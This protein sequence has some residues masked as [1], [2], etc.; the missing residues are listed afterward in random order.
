MPLRPVLGLQQS[1]SLVMT[2]QLLQSIKLLQFSNV[3]LD[4]YISS[5][6]ERNPLLKRDESYS[7]DENPPDI[8][9]HND[10]EAISERLDTSLENLFPDDPGS[11]DT[12]SPSL[13]AQWRSASGK[14]PSAPSEGAW[15]A[16]SFLTAPQTL[17]DQLQEQIPL[18]FKHPAERFLASQLAE[19][20]EDSGYLSDFDDIPARTGAS[21]AELEQVLLTLQQNIDPPGLFARNLAECLALQLQSK[22]RLDPAMRALLQNLDL[23]ARRDFAALRRICGVDEADLID[24]LAEIRM[25]DPK[26]GAAFMIG[27]AEPIIPEVV[28][29][30]APDGSWRVELND[31][32]LPRVLIDQVYCTKVSSHSSKQDQSFISEC[33]QN[34]NW[35]VRALDQRSKSI[36]KVATEIVRQQDA[37]LMHGVNHL[38]PLKLKTIADIIGMHESTVS[39]ITA[40]KFMLTP[41]GTFEMRYFFTA[42]IAAADG[43]DAH[44]AEAVRNRIRHLIAQESAENVLSDDALVDILKQAGIDVARRTVAKYREAMGIPSSVQRRRE[45]KALSSSL[46]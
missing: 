5:E 32:A 36:L 41:R 22:E 42:A 3:E 26:P 25:L 23:L 8:R 19:S 17:R 43:G 38:R 4:Q 21:K 12:I 11:R 16:E 35:L 44:S 24:M 14:G 6:I 20:L 15:N 45:K 28:V 31:E 37:F 40:H 39:R 9:A 27:G 29:S 13:L 7:A 46:R 18:I 30:S 33:L 1:Q 34:A 2:P 10:A